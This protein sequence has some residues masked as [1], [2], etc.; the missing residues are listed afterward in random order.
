MGADYEA[1]LKDALDVIPENTP[2]KE[3]RLA[4]MVKAES[5][6]AV[7]AYS[8]QIRWFGRRPGQAN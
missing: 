2:Q 8:R 5:A 1:M 6:G 4:E 7:P 3:A